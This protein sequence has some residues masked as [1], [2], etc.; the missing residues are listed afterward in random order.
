[1]LKSM[2]A[3]T[4]FG[5]ATDVPV[6]DYDPGKAKKLL[7]EA[8]LADGFSMPLYAYRDRPYSEAVL[9]YLRAVGITA[10]LRFMQWKALRPIIQEGK[11]ALAH[12]TWGSQG[13]QDASASVS[14]YFQFSPDDYARDEE[15]RKW[16]ETA[17]RTTDP[18]KRKELYAKALRKIADQ[19]YA[20][21][22]FMY[23][24]TY[25]FNSSLDYRV[26]PDEL[27]HFYMAKWK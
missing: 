18:T 12:L 7:A 26:T 8:G 10:D 4:Q 3:P 17:D 13:I 14:N 11:A 21:P 15:V 27:A 9:G 5:C 16:L 24:R 19:A 20:V 22:L 25:A 23:G 6:F 1:V 2:C